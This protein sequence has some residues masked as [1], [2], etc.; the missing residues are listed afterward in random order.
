MFNDHFTSAII[1]ETT[2]KS[3]EYRDLIKDNKL[4]ATWE[5]SFANEIGRLAQGIRD[6]EGTETIWFIP[7]SENPKD[8]LKDIT[9]GRIV[10]SY[11]PQKT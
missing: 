11:R 5:H 8:R 10:V 4:R 1:D 9:Y 2:G 3:L 6:I 7:K